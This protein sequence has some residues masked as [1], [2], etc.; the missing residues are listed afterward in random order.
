MAS[1][2]SEDPSGMDDACYKFVAQE[3]SAHTVAMPPLLR[4]TRKHVCGLKAVCRVEAEE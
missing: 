2:M 1:K 3:L 4:P